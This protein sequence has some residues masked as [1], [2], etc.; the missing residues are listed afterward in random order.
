MKKVVFYGRYSSQLQ[1]EQSIEGQLHVCERYAEQ[2]DMKIVE[3][4]ID[5]AITGKTD[6][7]PEFQRMIADSKKCGFEAVLVYK[8]DRFA[9]NRYDSALYKKKLRDNGVKVISATESITDTP[10][11]IIM[12]G[13][14]EAMD[15]YYSAELS[16][17]T[18]RGKEESFRKGKFIGRLA[19]FGYKV[20]DHKLAVDETKSPIAVELFKRYAAGETQNDLVRDLNARGIPNAEGRK[21]N[22]VNMSILLQ[23]T[24]YVGKYTV[25]TMEGEMP[26]PAI[27]EP[28]LF[29]EVQKKK[30]ESLHRARTR[31]RTFSYLLILF[32]Y[33]HI[34]NIQSLP[35][36]LLIV[37]FVRFLIVRQSLSITSSREL[38]HSL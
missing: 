1:T 37:D 21:W 17:K 34:D 35:V 30:A 12:E 31:N 26:C 25:K 27:I 22:T 36:M 20:V 15:E 10:E 7:R 23:N 4:Y 28:K 3:H 11:G 29:D 14:L 38:K 18:K 16:R 13:L 2:N 6:K 24:I 19:P 9:R 5:R 8:L 32:L 33:Y